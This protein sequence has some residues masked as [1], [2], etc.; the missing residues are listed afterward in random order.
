MKRCK[1]TLNRTSLTIPADQKIA[2]PWVNVNVADVQGCV[3][4]S[5]TYC[6]VRLLTSAIQPNLLHLELNMVQ[7]EAKDADF[8][9]E[10]TDD[11]DV[12]VISSDGVRF[13]VPSY[14]LAWARYD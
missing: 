3:S 9:A 7:S 4:L 10:F 8:I 5:C 11:G 6:S 13:R 2:L 12:C 14:L 1:T